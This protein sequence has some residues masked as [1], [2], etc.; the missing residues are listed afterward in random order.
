MPA[1]KVMPKNTL[2][3]AKK[4]VM[5]A[6]KNK[7]TK[8]DAAKNKVTKKDAA[9]NKVTNKNAKNDKDKVTKDDKDTKDKVTKDKMP[10][11]GGAE[12]L[13]RLKHFLGSRSNLPKSK[14]VAPK[15]AADDD[16]YS[17]DSDDA[18]DEALDGNESDWRRVSGHR[19]AARREDDETPATFCL[20]VR[21]KEDKWKPLSHLHA[22]GQTWLVMEYAE[23]LSDPKQRAAVERALSGLQMVRKP[24]PPRP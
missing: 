17:F 14:P 18:D 16:E 12:K 13:A 21:G 23:R 24:A 9:K 1:A 20:Q 8:K 4:K 15:P 6:A 5:P 3:A 19:S 2:P 10:C 11:L 22:D 7:V